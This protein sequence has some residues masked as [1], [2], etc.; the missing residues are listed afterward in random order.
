[1]GEEPI[2]A[3]EAPRIRE[4]SKQHQDLLVY[5]PQMEA[6]LFLCGRLFQVVPPRHRRRVVEMVE[7][8][9]V[10]EEAGGREFHLPCRK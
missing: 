4:V 7:E 6:H 8:V 3:M 10:E 1:M 2:I 5:A 9:A